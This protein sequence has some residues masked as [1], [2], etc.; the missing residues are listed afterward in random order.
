MG[1][2]ASACVAVHD[3]DVG[4]SAARSGI[5][6]PPEHELRRLR[7]SLLAWHRRHGLPAPWRLSRDPYQALVA[8]VMAQQTQM[9]RVLPKFEQFLTAFPTI[10][11]LAR[12][13]RGQ[14]LRLWA[15]L[16][17]NLRAVRL[18]RAA[19]QVVREGGFPRTAEAL[20]RIE[21]VGPFTAA[22]VASFAFGERV[23]AVDTNVRRVVGRLLRGDDG[24]LGE[25]TLR[26]AADA[27]VAPRAA[28]RWN[29][30]MM[31]L[32]ARVCT[33]REP[34]CAVCP[35]APWC[36]YRAASARRRG[37]G[38]RWTTRRA[39]EPFRG[40]RR[41]YRGRIIEALR[42]LPAGAALTRRALLARLNVD[43]GLDKV[44]LAELIAALQRDGLVEVD[45]RGRVRLP[46]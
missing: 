2:L 19:Q 39:S 46:S 1:W 13:S 43:G 40:S 45:A 16:G 10:E 29:Q 18:H 28:G 25:E 21:G 37:R 30:A 44:R 38:A 35:L 14:V 4:R 20:Q 23:A 42:A 27:L 9:A 32:G 31:D 11:A 5:R 33:A 17:Y 7:R 3:R 34:R 15:P 24:S 22:I 36:R 26:A 12:A 41:Y 6:L 8:A